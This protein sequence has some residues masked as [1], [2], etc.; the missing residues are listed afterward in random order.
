MIIFATFSYDHVLF[1]NDDLSFNFCFNYVLQLFQLFGKKIPF[2]FVSLIIN[3]G[4]F[5][6]RIYTVDLVTNFRDENI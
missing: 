3:W 2:V 4:T 1:K 5:I 6:Y